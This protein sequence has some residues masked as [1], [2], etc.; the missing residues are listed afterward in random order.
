MNTSHKIIGIAGLPRSGK[1][2]LAQYFIN[3]GFFGVSLGD[4]VRE[5]SRTRHSDKPD[6]ISVINMTETANWLRAE[7]GADFALKVAMEKFLNATKTSPEIKGLVLFSIRTPVEADYILKQGGELVWVEASDQ[8]RYERAMRN[9]R[10]D[11]TKITLEEF[12]SQEKIQ[13]KPSPKLPIKVQMNVE[14]VKSRATV[15]FNNDVDLEDFK[16]SASE[17]V[18]ELED[19]LNRKSN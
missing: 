5:I 7:R 9:L 6:P 18:K 4:I 19:K 2:S 10:A 3:D 13:W 8:T 15:T 14:Y 1:D 16:K 12:T 17:F 11:E